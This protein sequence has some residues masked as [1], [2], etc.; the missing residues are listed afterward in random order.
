[1]ISKGSVWIITD[2]VANLIDSL[3]PSVVEAMNGVFGIEFYVPESTRLDNFTMRWYTRSRKDHPNDPTLKL[4]IFGLLG[5]DTTWAVAQAAEK[6]KVAKTI[7]QIPPASNNCTGMETL[8]NLRNG[9]A[10]LKEILQSKSE[11]LSGYFDLSRGQLQAFKFQ[12]IN[13]VGKA[14]SNWV[15]EC[16]RWNFTAVRSKEINHGSLEEHH[17]KSESCDLARRI[18][19]SAERLGNSNKCKEA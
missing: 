19:K 11:G 7:T 3:N 9:P 1:M 12:I 4:S 2:R 15:L 18:Y 16:R 8:K 6:A 14:Q 13:V 5:Y 10:L 17:T